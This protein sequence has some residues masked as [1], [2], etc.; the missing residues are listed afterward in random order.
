M[1]KPKPYQF[2]Y[3]YGKPT[4]LRSHLEDDD[5]LVKNNKII[6]DTY[7]RFRAPVLLS[8]E[9]HFT[10]NGKKVVEYYT[11]EIMDTYFETEDF[12]NGIFIEK[13]YG[14]EGGLF[15]YRKYNNY[16]DYYINLKEWVIDI[17]GRKTE[18]EVGIPFKNT[19]I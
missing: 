19:E 5:P 6:I 18:G 16:P 3:D 1:K 8:Y 12:G 9:K 14:S 4:Q 15:Y 2:F 7:G 11:N 13:G 10:R 17:D